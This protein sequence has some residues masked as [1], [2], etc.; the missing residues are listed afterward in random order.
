ML[1]LLGLSLWSLTS[2]ETSQ[3]N[4]KRPQV[5]E[6]RDLIDT[7]ICTG[8]KEIPIDCQNIDGNSYE[9]PSNYTLGFV[10]ISGLDKIKI[11]NYENDL[12]NEILRLKRLCGGRCK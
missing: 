1:L 12:I 10:S 11:I 8:K 4:I 5:E 6:C 9:C 3:I 2:C 7:K